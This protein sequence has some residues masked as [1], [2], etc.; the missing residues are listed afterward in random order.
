MI[1]R[2][3]K[4]QG[5]QPAVIT[6][7]D[8]R[9]VAPPAELPEPAKQLWGELVDAFP[10]NRFHVS[11]RP[12]LALYCRAVCQANIAFSWLE[13]CGAAHGSA[14]SPWQK[15][16]DS[17]VKQVAVL[18]TRLRLCPQSRLDRKVAGPAARTPSTAR[19]W[20]TDDV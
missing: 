3:R 12:L 14:I 2:G 13:K 20:R 7:I 6:D 16:A 4:L 15:I 9:R 8:C 18:S 11:D 5:S 1:Q 10:A 17:A 19:P